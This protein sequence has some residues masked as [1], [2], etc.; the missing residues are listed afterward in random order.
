MSTCRR[1][2]ITAGY[3]WNSGE[4]PGQAEGHPAVTPARV[5]DA[6]LFAEGAAHPVPP[7]E[8]CGVQSLPAGGPA[9]RQPA[10]LAATPLRWVTTGSQEEGRADDMASTSVLLGKSTS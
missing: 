8:V 9:H 1:E 2:D 6:G 10:A 7:Y 3:S 4:W 5:S